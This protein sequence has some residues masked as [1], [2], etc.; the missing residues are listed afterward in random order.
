[1]K[2]YYT[3]WITPVDIVYEKLIVVYTVKNSSHSV[4]PDVHHFVHKTGNWSLSTAISLRTPDPLNIPPI[5]STIF[6]TNLPP[7][8]PPFIP[9]FQPMN[10]SLIWTPNIS[11][12]YYELRSLLYTMFSSVQ[13]LYFSGSN[14]L[15]RNLPSHTL[16]PISHNVS[17][18]ISRPYQII[19]L[20][21]FILG[22]T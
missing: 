16:I 4:K 5:R 20:R 1:M 3:A 15:L 13:S 17:D 7:N 2:E 10:F 21:V 22:K 6:K 19:R 11:G 14:T 18:Q 12:A 9:R 8:F